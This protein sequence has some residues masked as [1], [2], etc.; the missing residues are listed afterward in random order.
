MTTAL[1]TRPA[2]R[3]RHVAAAVV[4]GAAVALLLLAPDL[5]GEHGRLAAVLVLQAVLVAAWAP[6]TAPAGAV[7]VA[8]LGA[9][10]AVGADLAVGLLAPSGDRPGPGLLLAVAGPAMI[11]A[12]LHQM[13]RRPPRT[14]V[15]GSLGSVALLVAACCALALLLLPDVAGDDG[16]LSGSPLLVV[17]AALVAGHLVDAVLP[18][19]TLAAGADRG[20][21][22]L[23]LAV[24]AGV[25]VA[26][27]ESGTGELVDV[28]S[29]VT[30]GLVLGL[31]AALAGTAASFVLGEAGGRGAMGA[32]VAVEAVLPLAVCAPVLLALA[33]V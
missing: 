8:V 13:L 24:A 11:A 5:L 4:A 2:T 28:V 10:A 26:L 7:G 32:G 6:A 19:P 29:G 23:L 22:G 31:V 16:D 20:V 27:L 3:A 9:A 1:D 25:A 33:V 12:V 18:R 17:G 14:D 30:T 21:P 15:V